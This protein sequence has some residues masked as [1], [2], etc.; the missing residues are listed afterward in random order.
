MDMITELCKLAD[1]WNEEALA[2]REPAKMTR[3]ESPTISV[4]NYARAHTLEACVDELEL[5]I[6]RHEK[7]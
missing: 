3:E 1:K 2:W 6:L 4:R 5:L 7:P